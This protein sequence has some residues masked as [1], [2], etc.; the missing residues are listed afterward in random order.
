MKFANISIIKFPESR[1]GGV[2]RF[3]PV[4]STALCKIQGGVV[5]I[6]SSI[7]VRRD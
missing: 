3:E 5:D 7:F 2:V 4:H 1:T 6:I